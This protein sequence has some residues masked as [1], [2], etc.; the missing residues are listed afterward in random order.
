M[1]SILTLVIYSILIILTKFFF[2]NKVSLEF[3]TKQR[4]VAANEIVT[5]ANMI[6]A[7]EESSQFRPLFINMLT[8]E[9]CPSNVKSMSL[10]CAGA[11]PS[12]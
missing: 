12:S 9:P 5:T 2:K 10:S 4:K 6:R 1:I 8:V 7:S 3:L 11:E